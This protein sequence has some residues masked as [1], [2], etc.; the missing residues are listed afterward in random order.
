MNRTEVRAFE[1]SWLRVRALHRELSL[2]SAAQPDAKGSEF[3]V[4]VVN[5]VLEEAKDLVSSG[6]LP[7]EISEPLPDSVTCSDMVVVLAVHLAALETIRAHNT[8]ERHGRRYW[9]VEDDAGQSAFV[10]VQD[11]LDG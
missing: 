10:P 8:K 3:K 2:L 11:A 5:L 4:R 6:D 9:I 1:T 7:A